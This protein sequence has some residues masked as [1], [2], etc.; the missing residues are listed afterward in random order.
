[1]TPLLVLLL[2]AAPVEVSVDPCVGV[3]AA[4]VQRIALVELSSGHVSTV[5]IRARLSCRER[6]VEVR[7]DDP[8][9]RK[10]LLREIDLT[11]LAE[12]TRARYVALAIAELVAASWSELLLPK[13]RVAPAGPVASEA[14]RAAAVATLPTYRFK[15][16]ASATG[17]DFPKAGLILGGADLRLQYSAPGQVGLAFDFAA[18]HGAARAEAG[19]INV[20]TIGGAAFVTWSTPQGL[21][22][23]TAG[24]GVRAAGARLVGVPFDTTHFTG[25]SVAAALAGPCAMGQLAIGSPR[26]SVTVGLEVGIPVLRLRGEVD[27]ATVVRL[28]GPWIS[29]SVGGAFEL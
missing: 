2:A 26:A 6:T 7:V 1:M 21:L 25:A 22:G 8:V 17:R 23:V 4:E 24:A 20:D 3:S 27:G 14:E 9:T 13:P 15:L 19:T 12:S 5:P 29:A 18:E 16:L 28:E 11:P 10:A